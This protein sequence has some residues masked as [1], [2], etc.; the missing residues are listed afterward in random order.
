MDAKT[1]AITG[2]PKMKRRN[3]ACFFPR[4][5]RKFIQLATP[6]KTIHKEMY[7]CQAVPE[8]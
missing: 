7:G 6:L 3:A 2:S 8:T 5:H 1:D 4:A